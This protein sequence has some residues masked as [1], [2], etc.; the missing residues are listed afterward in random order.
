M[1][2]LKEIKYTDQW[3]QDQ[4][5]QIRLDPSSG[6]DVRFQSMIAKKNRR[7]ALL[8]YAWY[9]AAAMVLLA[10]L[11]LMPFGK[12]E[13]HQVVLLTPDDVENQYTQQRDFIQSS[14]YLT[15]KSSYQNQAD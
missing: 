1:K 2:G 15:M 12:N 13:I 14:E 10:V 3:F 5:S 7:S 11:T 9:G 8:P 4:G 6:A